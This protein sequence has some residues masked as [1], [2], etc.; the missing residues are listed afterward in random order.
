MW[1]YMEQEQGKKDKES[2]ENSYKTN[3]ANAESI[4]MLEVSDHV[5]AI[6]NG[7]RSI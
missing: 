1:Y 6:H 4:P 2:A 5:T 7:G 3:D